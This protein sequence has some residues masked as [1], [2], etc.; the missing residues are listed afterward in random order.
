MEEFDK[1]YAALN[2]AQ[3]QAVN[4]I[5][6]PVLV[7]AGPGTGKTQLLSARVAHILRETD[8]LPQNILCLTFTESGAQNMRD[9]LTRFIGKSAYDVQISTYHAFGGD[10]IRR[11]PEYFIDTRLE[12][13]VDELG[14]RQ[15]LSTIVDNLSYRSPLKQLR[16]HIGDLMSTISEVK[17]GLLTPKDLRDIAASNL[18]VIESASKIIT[19]SL[20]D[21]TKRLPSKLATAEPLFGEIY[22]ELAQ[23]AEQTSIKAPFE[24]LAQ[25]AA[26]QLEKAL[27]EA[28]ETGKTKPLTAWKNDWLAKNADNQYVLAGALEAARMAELANVLEAYTQALEDRGL[29]DFDDMI[30]RA[31]HVLETNKDLRYTL[32]ERYQ[33]LLLDEFQDTNQAQLRLVELLTDNPAVERKPNV[34]AVGD[35]DQ[36]IYAFQGAQ[37]S[38]ML[39]FFRMFRDVLVINLSEN[40]RSRAEILETAKNISA[41]IADNLTASLPGLEKALVA[42]NGNLPKC[43]LARTEYSSEIA[44]RVGIAEHI[45]QLLAGG[46]NPSEIAV[47]A[48]KH[49]YLE[50]LVPYLSG[51]P[52]RYERREN[53]LDAPVI[54]QLLTMSRL[55]LALHDRNQRLADSLWP[56]MLSYSFWEFPVSSIWRLSWQAADVRKPWSGLLLDHEQFRPVALL[57]LS[58]ATQ[59]ETETLEVMLDRLI[60]TEEVRTGEADLP[61]MRSKLRS[62]L[63][64]EN[65]SVLYQTATELTVLRAR[66]HEHQ[67]QQE[68]ALGLRDLLEFVAEYEA[69]GE[70]MV[71]TSPYNEAADAVQLMTVFK[72]KG[73][74]FAHVF[75]LCCQDDVWGSG[76][77]GN[78]NKLTLPANLAPI[79]HAG[80]TEDERLRIF[81]VALTRAKHGLYLTSHASTHAGK[82]PPRLKYL[83]EAEQEDGNVVSAALP[84]PFATLQQDSTDALPLEALEL[85]WRTPHTQLTPPLRELLRERLERYRLSPTH[86]TKFIDL[87][88]GGPQAFLLDTLLHFPVAPSLD[89]AFGNAM[90]ETLEWLQLQTN[91]QGKTPPLKAANEYAAD[92]L[93]RQTLTAEQIALQQARAE[94]ALEAFLKTHTF[95]PGNRPEYNFRDEG[96]VLP[97][98]VRLGGKIDLLEVDK[99]RKTITIVD[100]KTGA[101]GAD[102]AK[103]HRY[104]LQLYCYK[105]LLQ[106]S[107][108]FKDYTV[109]QGVLVFVE[110]D[111][112]SGKITRHTVTFK[113]DELTRVAKLLTALWH[114]IQAL[115]LPDVSKYSTSL[116]DIRQFEQD[117]L[118]YMPPDL[119]QAGDQTSLL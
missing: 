1:V 79:R 69:A 88:H 90:H 109:E 23:M 75:L 105:L 107:H 91:Q 76:A 65:E 54:R 47:L 13:P 58:L 32:Q 92:R 36:A 80:T 85:N 30:L 15:I 99:D 6:G 82:K 66:L 71:N 21:Y 77:R 48:P 57:F 112:N 43:T 116:A 42:A 39:D 86:L 104:E 59:V 17:R 50:P 41:Q 114:R 45:K 25:L 61:S 78:G 60:G 12:R 118:D 84:A 67:L 52:L 63:E 103:R 117:L 56:E 46:V 98:G 27:T 5:D 26:Q 62:A 95:T 37:Y 113:D 51:V 73:L 40:Y 3:K 70:Q 101:L 14:R 34:L 24:N 22:G 4:A 72:A 94:N 93:S 49:R 111:S 29:Y 108:T 31:I 16:H 18:A 8:T 9:R 2:A 106:N 33:Y 35:D 7:V 97:G 55:V 81:F 89:L 28:A 87:E 68:S 64:H 119:S 10:L 115:N 83:S 74:E 20:A 100:Y 44:E 19:D 53:I 102:P 110:P 96:V 38:N 11:Y